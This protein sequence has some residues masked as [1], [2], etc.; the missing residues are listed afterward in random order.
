ML[1]YENLWFKGYILRKPSILKERGGQLWQD[2]IDQEQLS[3]V[4]AEQFEQFVLMLLEWSEK[5][6][7]TTITNLKSIIAYHFQD[8]L[9]LGHATNLNKVSTIADV[10]TGGGFPGI[11]L[12][13]KY[14]HLR[15]I[16]IEVKHKRRLFLEEV[17]HK[18][19]LKNIEIYP[20]DW[21]TFLR[22]TEQQ[23]VDIVCARASLQPAELMRMFKPASPYKQGALVY[24]AAKDWQPEKKEVPFLEKE[25]D[26]EVGA[27]KRKLIFFKKD[28]LQ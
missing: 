23:D 27:R 6:N 14:P 20:H 8:S 21:R 1:A 18:L 12:K 26:Y 4:Q 22:T 9:S 16:L 5:I 17:I 7:L 11:P 13:I 24:W 19:K 10:G 15:V 28:A 25:F 2:F 3:A